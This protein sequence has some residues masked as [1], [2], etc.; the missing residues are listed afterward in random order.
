M[1]RTMISF[2]IER[3]VLTG[4]DAIAKADRKSRSQ[5]LRDAAATYVKQ[6]AAHELTDVETQEANE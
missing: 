5:V 6:A 2:V 1:Q 4:V 3:E